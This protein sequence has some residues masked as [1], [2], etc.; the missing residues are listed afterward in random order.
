MTDNN[1]TSLQRSFILSLLLLSIAGLAWLFAPFLPSLF[2]ALLIAISTYGQ[3]NKFLTKHSETR[4]ALL[5]TLLVT[6]L[7]ILPLSY[8]LL[9]S[10]LEISSLIQSINN[11]FTIEKSNQILNQTISGLPLPDTIRDTIKS[12]FVNN[13]EGVLIAIKDFSVTILKS[14]VSLS[15]NFVFFVIITIFS[16]FY[17]YTD[18][19][20]I[21][22]RIKSL[23]PLDNKLNEI[24]FNQFSGLSVILVGSVFFIA[25]LQGVVFSVGVMLVGLPAIY[26]GIAMALA[27]FIPVL[28][29][30]IIWLPLSIYLYAQGQILESIIIVIFGAIIIGLLIDNF[31]RPIVIKKFSKKL[32]TSNAL[33]HTFMTV[34]STLAG[35]IQF[36]ILGLFVGPIIAAM[37][38]SIFD[39]YTLKYG[40]K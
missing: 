31:V 22:A 4:S 40:N 24:L 20:K 9:I 35:I 10:G 17:F 36:G 3:Y 23:S 34:M 38:I 18:G 19:K 39:V 33:D 15:S 12:S 29:G 32:N 13:I 5:L 27:S 11:N 2:L 14:I 25:L 6:L 21:V 28:G 16:L 26:F 8:V 1:E 37:A 7:L 30:L